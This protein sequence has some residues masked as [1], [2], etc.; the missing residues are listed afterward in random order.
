MGSASYR[1]GQLA[2]EVGIPVSTVRYY[3]RRGLLAPE[4]RSPGNYRLYGASAC[5]RLRFVRAAQRAG[6]TLRDIEALLAWRE[7]GAD[8]RCVRSLIERRL[9]SVDEQIARLQQDRE[10]LRSWLRACRDARGGCPVIEGLADGSDDAEKV[11]KGEKN[12]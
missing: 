4:G 9:R 6:F 8:R 3:E 12:A 7:T 1:I 11:E 10:V 5:E 2:K